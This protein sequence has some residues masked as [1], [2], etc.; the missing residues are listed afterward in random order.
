MPAIVLALLSSLAYGASDYLGGLK[1]RNLPLATVLLVSQAAALA[2]I[3]ATLTLAVG[4]IPAPRYLAWG[5]AT[6]LAE[7]VGLSALY[8]GLAVGKMSI[9]AAVAATA[10]MVPVIASVV[11]GDSPG[12]IQWLGIVVAIGGVGLLSVSS[13]RED[14]PRA[15]GRPAVSIVFGLL[16]AAGLG[17]SLLFMSHAA[18]G[19]VQWALISARVT[20]T[21]VFTIAF[22]AIR[23]SGNPAVRDWGWL[24]A[25]GILALAAE[26]FFAV[27]SLKGDLSVVSVLSS[28]YPMVTILLA[29]FHLGEQL[30]RR[31]IGGIAIVLAGAAALSV[32]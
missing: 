7:V 18:E 4:D 29:R 2:A 17:F 1:S 9:V 28:L 10:P 5:A 15:T 23:P 8:H 14:D 32:G 25:I 6:G 11:T 31:Q 27:A 13:S 22:L 30:S 12:T 21:G 19:S 20:A 24:A 26:A 16:T 3:V